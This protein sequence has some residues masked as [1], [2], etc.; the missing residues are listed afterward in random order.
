M[1]DF[2]ALSGPPPLQEP[3]RPLLVRLPQLSILLRLAR[4]TRAFV[5]HPVRLHLSSEAPSTL[6]QP[7]REGEWGIASRPWRPPTFRSVAPD[8]ASEM[9]VAVD[10]AWEN[11]GPAEVD[12]AAPGD[13]SIRRPSGDLYSW[14]SQTRQNSVARSVS[15]RSMRISCSGE[16]VYQRGSPARANPSST[17]P[18]AS[19]CK[20]SDCAHQLTV[21]SGK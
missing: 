4:P 1:R 3:N 17:R 13:I 2:P 9:N 8:A 14:R 12:E 10:Q 19:E 16:S 21:K 5:S 15:I 18:R 6:A 11:C 7:K 20:A